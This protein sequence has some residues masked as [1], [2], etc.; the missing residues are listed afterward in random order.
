MV[1]NLGTTQSQIQNVDNVKPFILVQNVD[2]AKSFILIQNAD[3]VN[4]FILLKQKTR[5]K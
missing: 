4:S 2:N 3:N 5:P 1:F